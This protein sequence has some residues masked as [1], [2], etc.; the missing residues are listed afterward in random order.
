MD[1]F[2]DEIAAFRGRVKARA[3]D[4]IEAAMKEAEEVSGWVDREK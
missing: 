4:K 1:S 2:E 3:R